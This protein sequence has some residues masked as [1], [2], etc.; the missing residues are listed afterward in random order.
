MP[1]LYRIHGFL[2]YF[3]ANESGEPVH[4]HVARGRQSPNAAK[5][6]IL[7]NGDVL[8]DGVGNGMTAKELRG[9]TEFLRSVSPD[10]VVS[11]QEVFGYV[12]FH[13]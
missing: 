5:F 7:E 2:I 10:I 12:R 9:I 11:W 6:W 13:A 8:L 3:W 1:G 4:V